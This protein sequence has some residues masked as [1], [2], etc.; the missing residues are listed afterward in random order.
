MNTIGIVLVTAAAARAGSAPPGG[1][2]QGNPSLH[3]ILSQRRQSVGI[4][5][6]P[7]VFNCKIL[8]IDIPRRIQSIL[9][10][11]I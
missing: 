8:P 6:R 11:S 5:L 7:A 2:D 10:R 4:A 3:K 1:E 9:E